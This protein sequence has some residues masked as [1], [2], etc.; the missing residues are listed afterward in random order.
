MT[1]GHLQ[2]DCLNTGISSGP[3][4]RCRVWE[5]FT[6]FTAD[7][8]YIFDDGG[9][10]ILRLAITAYHLYGRLRRRRLTG[11]VYPGVFDRSV[12]DAG[13][14]AIFRCHVTG[15]P[16]PMVD[17]SRDD[18]RPITAS[19]DHHRVRQYVDTDGSDVTELDDARCSDAGEFT[20]S[21]SNEFGACT[22]TASL[23]VETS[24]DGAISRAAPL[25]DMYAVLI[26][27]SA[28]LTPRTLRLD[29]FF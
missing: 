12:C 14:T 5:A 24:E 21:A 2:A 18:R 3:N 13:Q 9:L 23:V 6:F 22:A 1:Y 28:G 4:A 16:R 20:V 10:D 25:E 26:H 15:E 27:R 8:A 19:P 7:A 17:W 29:R 11:L